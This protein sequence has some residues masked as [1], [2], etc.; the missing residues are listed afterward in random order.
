MRLPTSGLLAVLLFFAILIASTRA[1][2]VPKVDLRG[3]GPKVGRT[4]RVHLTSEMKDGE[5]TVRGGVEPQSGSI[6]V[7]AVKD[8]E[9]EI[10][11]VDRQK[12]LK[13]RTKHIKQETQTEISNGDTPQVQKKRDDLDWSTVISERRDGKWSHN[14]EGRPPTEQEQKALSLLPDWDD[15]DDIPAGK[16]SPGCTWQSNVARLRRLFQ[17]RFKSLSGEIKSTFVRVENF[18]GAPCAVIESQGRLNGSTD[19]MTAVM[20]YKDIDYRSLVLGLVLKSKIEGTITVTNRL[21]QGKTALTTATKG[22]LV[23]EKTVEVK[24]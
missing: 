24:K 8:E 6:S 5:F 2:D 17:A 14:L 16:Q 12:V 4:Y 11:A 7:S 15:E 22:H 19:E 1:A 21:K 13:V 23:A 20:E 3:P 10:L 9:I 18:G